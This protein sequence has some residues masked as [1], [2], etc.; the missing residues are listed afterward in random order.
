MTAE[1]NQTPVY[2]PGHPNHFVKEWREFLDWTQ[3]KLAEMADVSQTKIARIESGERKL[4]TDFLQVLARVFN[5]PSSALLEVNPATKSGA[6]TAS[7]LLEWN[8]LTES[9]RA[10]VLKMVRALAG[11]DERVS[12]S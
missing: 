2:P 8:K 12:A 11:P 9:Q 7:L 3:E 10:D 5:V 1:T 6:Q 4:K